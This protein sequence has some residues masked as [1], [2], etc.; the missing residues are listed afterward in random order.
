MKFRVAIST[1]ALGFTLLFFYNNC[2][3]FKAVDIATSDQSNQGSSSAPPSS[4]PPS[5]Q[6]PGTNPLPPVVNKNW[7]HEPSGMRTVTDCPFSGSICDG[8]FNVYKTQAFA[9]FENAPLSAGSVL[10]SYLAAGSTTG[11][12]QWI[13]PLSNPREVFIGTWW[14][15]NAEFEG[16]GGSVANKMIFVSGIN[17]NNFL[18]WIQ[19]DGRDTPGTLTW[20]F[21]QT[22]GMNNCHVTGYFSGGCKLGPDWGPGTGTLQPNGATSGRIAAGSGWHKI[23]IYQKSSL[24]PNTQDGII[25]IWVDDV[26]HTNYTNLNLVPAGFID[27]Q[28]NNT[29]DGGAWYD[30]PNRDCKRAWHHYWDHF[31]ISVR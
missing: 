19:Y 7:S 4:Q 17:D 25:R 6:P 3:Q 31:Y 12:G 30:C 15:T 20:A 27:T 10:D 8:W 14:S 21:Q 23:E 13:V 1:G 26:E 11:N 18:N 16:N 29:W 28:I 24:G 9:N 22:G 2:S 5:S